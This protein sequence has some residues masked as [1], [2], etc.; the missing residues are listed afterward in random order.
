MH[1]L[2]RRAALNGKASPGDEAGLAFV[3]VA[4]VP[5]V[6]DCCLFTGSVPRLVHT[7][8]KDCCL[9]TL[10]PGTWGQCEQATILRIGVDESRHGAGEQA[11]VPDQ[12]HECDCDKC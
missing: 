8:P 9:L 6:W 12:W 7:D 2:A 3:A 1:G 5:L 11:A 4:L 10:P